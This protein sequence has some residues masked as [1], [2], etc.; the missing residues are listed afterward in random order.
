MA[1]S[2]QGVTLGMIEEEFGCGRRTAQRMIDALIDIFPKTDHRVDDEQRK[3]W[4]LPSRAIAQLLTPTAEELAAISF[5]AGELERVDAVTEA[6]ALRTLHHK[7]RALIPEERGRHLDADEEVLLVAMG[8]ATR[9][10]PRPATK[11]DIDAAISTA[12][13]GPFHLQLLYQARNDLRPSPR[14]VAPHGLLLGFRRYLVALDTTKSDGRMRHYRVEDILEAEV[15]STSFTPEESFNLEEHANRGFASYQDE[16]E[17]CE[18]VW[19][20]RPEAADRARRF[21]FHPL[22]EVET[23]SDGSLTVRFKASGLLEMCWHLYAWGDAVEVLE[24]PELAAM[25]AGHQRADFKSL[26]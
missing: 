23:G 17:Y 24:P 9:P 15:L 4:R 13:K 19:R 1:A 5:A 25:V 8:H 3:W 12:L 14:T 10:G 11:T 21:V 6:R 18:V 20:F 26:P 22:Q 7:V 16:R 2:H